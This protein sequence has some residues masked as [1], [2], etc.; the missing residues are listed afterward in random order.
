MLMDPIASICRDLGQLEILA[1]CSE[2]TPDRLQALKERCE[3][4]LTDVANQLVSGPEERFEITLEGL[5]TLYVSG[6]PVRWRGHL[7]V[8]DG[9]R[10]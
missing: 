5:Q 7:A 6:R 8:I 4:N 10:A 2:L 1:K 3:K 9:D